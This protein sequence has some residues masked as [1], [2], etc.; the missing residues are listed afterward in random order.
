M[1]VAVSLVAAAAV[2]VGTFALIRVTEQVR[3]HTAPPGAASSGGATPTPTASV[4]CRIPT[5]E[6]GAG[7]QTASPNPPTSNPGANAVPSV[8]AG[9]F[10][11]QTGAFTVDPTQPALGPGDHDLVDIP[12]VGWVET[13]SGLDNCS[14][15]DMLWNCGWSPD[16]Q[17]FAYSDD[18]CAPCADQYGEEFEAGRVHV[19]SA[20][21]DRVVTPAGEADELLGWT[22]QGIVVARIRA[23]TGTGAAAAV[24]GSGIHLDGHFG[25]TYDDY[26]VDPATGQETYLT[27]TGAFAANGSALWSWNGNGLIRYDLTD[28]AV[29]AVWPL[30]PTDTTPDASGP[31]E[32]YGFDAAGDPLILTPDYQLLLLTGPA[33]G[34][35]LRSDVA[36][37]SGVQIGSVATLPAGGLLVMTWPTERSTGGV[38]VAVNLWTPVAGWMKL[39]TLHG[40]S[41]AR[42]GFAFAGPGLGS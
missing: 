34:S 4:T 32:L 22:Q 7:A 42:A 10:D 35:V 36:T 28:G 3:S 20:A 16:G 5:V 21:G 24:A 40:G 9:F 30:P 27:T 1:Q 19:V 29:P 26:L 18:S 31:F 15:A 17:E 37:Q 13:S 6:Y 8:T 38:A 33:T 14:P 39:G 23:A 2:A 41:G 25:A 11:C 12:P